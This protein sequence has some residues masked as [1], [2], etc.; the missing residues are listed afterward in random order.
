MAPSVT[1]SRSGAFFSLK[2]PSRSLTMFPHPFLLPRPPPLLKAR[3]LSNS[4]DPATVLYCL[5]PALPSPVHHYASL[6]RYPRPP[7]FPAHSLRLSRL[8]STFAKSLDL[9]VLIESRERYD[10]ES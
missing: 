3:P 4:S 10:T 1:S 5:Q 6:G 2:L 9:N 7:P 8:H